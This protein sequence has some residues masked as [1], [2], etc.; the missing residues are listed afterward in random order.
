M[1]GRGLFEHAR[2]RRSWVDFHLG[3][4]PA[5]DGLRGIGVTTFILY[6]CI[7]AFENTNQ[8]WF[9]PGAYLWLELF[10]VQSGFLITSLLLDEW[11]R[12]GEIRLRNFYARRALRLLPALFAVV[13]FALVALWTFSPYSDAPGAWREVWGSLF[14]HQNWVGAFGTTKFPVYLSHTWS[15][16]IEEQFY[17]AAP[18]GLVILLAW[19]RSLRRAIPFIAAG[20]LASAVWMGVMASRTFHPLHLQRLY[21]GTDTR[22]QGLLVGVVLAVA[23]HSGLWL[24]PGDERH[25]RIARIWGAVGFAVLVVML[26]SAD[27]REEAWYYGGFLLCSVSVV[28]ILSELLRHPEGRP[29]PVVAAVPTHRRDDLRPVPVALA[30]DHGH[31]PVHVLARSAHDPLPGRGVVHDGLDLVPLPRAS[32]PRALGPSI[33]AHDARAHRRPPGAPPCPGGHRTH[34]RG[35]G[36]TGDGRPACHLE[37]TNPAGRRRRRDDALGRTSRLSRA[38]VPHLCPPAR[39]QAAGYDARRWAGGTTWESIRATRAR[40]AG[41]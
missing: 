36:T 41:G 23:I 40:A 17:L 3:Y 21:Y 11:Y 29:G 1:A 14:Y 10:F 25:D 27:L 9:L 7:I 32:D 12:T 4:Q 8:S 26:F 28:G 16:S 35:D 18:I 30:A 39:T 38:V 20:A 31:R 37:R 34:R 2:V 33:P 6:H 24:R 15:L 13:L 5:F 19:Q 22:A